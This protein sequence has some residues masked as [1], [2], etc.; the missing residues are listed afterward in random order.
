M[1]ART[2]AARI[3]RHQHAVEVL[4]PLPDQVVQA[5]NPASV[6]DRTV[7]GWRQR[8]ARGVG[9]HE[10]CDHLS[11]ALYVATGAESDRRILPL[12]DRREAFAL[13]GAVRASGEPRDTR[14]GTA[15]IER[16]PRI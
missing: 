9:G 6:G 10:V 16:G 14:H 13:R 4:D 5:A 11:L 2:D 15:V 1:L 12:G 7:H 8:G 3:V